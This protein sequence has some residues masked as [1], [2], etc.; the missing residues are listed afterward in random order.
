MAV[1]TLDPK[2]ALIVI[3]LQ[4]GIMA[5]PAVRSRAIVGNAVV[6][7]LPDGY[8]LVNPA[9]MF[10]QDDLPDWSSHSPDLDVIEA[11]LEQLDGSH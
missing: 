3:D 11:W 2:S 6:T 8:V 7:Y 4:K 1:T 10:S 5:A 9:V